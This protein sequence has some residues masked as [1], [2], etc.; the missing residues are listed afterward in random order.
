M[1]IAYIAVENRVLCT[2]ASVA[3]VSVLFR[4]KERGTRVKDRE[5]N[6]AFFDSCSISRSVKAENPFLLS[7]IAPKPNGN[8]CY[9]GYVHDKGYRVYAFLL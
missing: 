3:S 6:G 2:I 5:K 4:S 8:D 7:L 9:A 1:T